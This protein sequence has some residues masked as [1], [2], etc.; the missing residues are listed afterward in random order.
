M[1]QAVEDYPK[2]IIIYFS[3]YARINGF[4]EKP[5]KNKKADLECKFLFIC[6]HSKKFTH[7]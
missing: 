4:T 7:V 2:K 1:Y 5:K 3:Y 6:Y